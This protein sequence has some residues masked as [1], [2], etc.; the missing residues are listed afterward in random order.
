MKT[1]VVILAGGYSSRMNGFKPLMQLG[2][3]SL[4]ERTVRLFKGA[5]VA[6][7]VVVTGHRRSEVKAEAVRLG[8]TSVYNKK[9]DAGMYSSVCAGVREMK[10]MD[11]FFLLPVDI[12]LVRSVTICS[13]LKKNVRG[14]VVY[15]TYRGE[16]GHPP[17]ISARLI[18]AILDFDGDGGLK[19]LLEKY[20]GYDLA[21]W[22]EGI[23]RD[24]DTEDDFA[25]MQERLACMKVGSRDEV[26][27]LAEQT[28]PPQGLAHGLAVARVARILGT[29][30]NSKGCSLDMGIVY[31][32]AL[33]HDIAKGQAHHELRGAELLKSLGLTDLCGPVAAHKSK[34][35]SE[36]GTISEKDIVCLADKMVRG[37]KR[38]VVVRRFEEKLQLYKG[39]KEACKA[40]RRRLENVQTLEKAVVKVLGH[41]L[42]DI[43]QMELSR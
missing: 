40:I 31:N 12:P 5:D 35:L 30:L 7:I 15:P 23:L 2:G 41:P 25:R 22:D 13:L 11:N 33:L 10:K 21:V 27:L 32:S 20:P 4:L 16:R 36:K 17:L 1:G 24:A 19:T 8:V 38:M 28:M 14:G 3:K 18:P 9:Y 43:V 29:A 37:T 42:E 34:K 6:K 26:Q 39:D